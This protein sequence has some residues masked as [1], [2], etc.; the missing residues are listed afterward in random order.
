M[1]SD[2]EEPAEQVRAPIV[3][4]KLRNGSGAKGAQEGG[5]VA[6]GKK[7]AAPAR[8]PE[9]AKQAGETRGRWSWVEPSV[10]TPRM[11]TALEDGVKGN[12]W[13]SLIDHQRW[14]NKFFATQGLFSLAAAHELLRQPSRR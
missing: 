6:T 10:W 11:L 2:A 1:R 12:K 5:L 7:E 14:P 3:A 13:F 8:V 4:T 9:K